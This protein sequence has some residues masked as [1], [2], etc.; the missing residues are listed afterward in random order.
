MPISVK[1]A[2][3]PRGGKAA[4]TETPRVATVAVA[5]AVAAVDGAPKQAATL[6]SG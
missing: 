2:K 6:A 1:A 3:R 4:V 5:T